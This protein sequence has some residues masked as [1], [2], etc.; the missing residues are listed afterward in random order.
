MKFEKLLRKGHRIGAGLFLISMI[1]AG[2]ASA[3]GN[4]ESPWIYTPL[5]FLFALTLS[6]T[7]MLVAPWIRKWRGAKSHA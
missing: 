4:I 7:Y 3:Q 5:P 2:I 1:P 6:G